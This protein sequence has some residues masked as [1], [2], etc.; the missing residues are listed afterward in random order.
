MHLFQSTDHLAFFLNV[1]DMEVFA[2]KRPKAC[3]T[4]AEIF[5]DD[6]TAVFAL[7]R[8]LLYWSSVVWFQEIPIAQ[9]IHRFSVDVVARPGTAWDAIEI[10]LLHVCACAWQV[11]C[12][13][14]NALLK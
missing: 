9:H 8:Q 2:D 5:K 1:A 6:A 4:N 13:V 12:V 7:K 14:A 10:N 11:L 3:L